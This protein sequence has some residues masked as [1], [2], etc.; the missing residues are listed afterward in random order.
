MD[1]LKQLVLVVNGSPAPTVIA[2][3]LDKGESKC[4]VTGV[5]KEVP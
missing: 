2:L 5:S 3:A 1:H 4:F